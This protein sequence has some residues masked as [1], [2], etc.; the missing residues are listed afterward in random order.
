[1]PFLAIANGTLRELT[2]G[3]AMSEDASH[4]LS[5]AP[6]LAIV[7][8]YTW[9]VARRWPL[10]TRAQSMVVG[11]GGFLFA[12][13]FE[14]G[15]GRL[16]GR[17]WGA[18]FRDYNIFAGRIWSLVPLALLVAPEFH[19]RRQ[20]RKQPEAAETMARRAA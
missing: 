9:F 19:R 5:T 17:S 3:R 8:A 12:T 7:G 16:E 20:Q 10:Q 15:F 11:V 14:F 18:L 4:A 6:L 13:V 2:Y 1:M